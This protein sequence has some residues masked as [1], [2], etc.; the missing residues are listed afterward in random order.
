MPFHR[1]SN[2][3]AG[4]SRRSERSR[5][6]D[7]RGLIRGVVDTVDPTD[8]TM[9]LRV[10]TGSGPGKRWVGREVDVDTTVAELVLPDANG[11]HRQDLRDVFPGNDVEIRFS[12][13]VFSRKGLR[14]RKVTHVAP[15]M[16]VGGLRALWL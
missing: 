12:G 5:G 4:P 8:G 7:D 3:N 10:R 2:S 9:R 11:D 1:M 6:R 13:A 16:P 14:A 15:P